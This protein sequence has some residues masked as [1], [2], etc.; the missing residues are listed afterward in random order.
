MG[1]ESLCTGMQYQINSILLTTGAYLSRS[2][3]LDDIVSL[4]LCPL[5]VYDI[6]IESIIDELVKQLLGSLN[7]LDKHQ[8]RR[9]KTL[10]IIIREMRLD[11]RCMVELKEGEVVYRSYDVSNG[12]QFSTLLSNKQ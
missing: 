1:M 11:K 8:H 10:S 12:Y 6:H 4:C 7:A 5:R 2:E 3:A 9:G